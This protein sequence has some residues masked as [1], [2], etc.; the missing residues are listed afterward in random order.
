[1]K[2][3]DVR[4]Q[5]GPWGSPE[6]Y[7]VFI[8]DGHGKAQQIVFWVRARGES[9]GDGFFVDIGN[10]FERPLGPVIKGEEKSNPRFS[11]PAEVEM[12]HAAALEPAIAKGG[13]TCGEGLVR[14]PAAPLS[15]C[16]PG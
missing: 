12:L 2:F 15:V 10:R 5:F 1:M 8:F 11:V 4:T 14:H 7:P 6:R 3:P 16:R 9:Q 13:D